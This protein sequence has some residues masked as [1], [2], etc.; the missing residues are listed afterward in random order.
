MGRRRQ[1]FQYLMRLPPAALAQ[2]P[3][4]APPGP[5][6]VAQMVQTLRRHGQR[7]PL[8]AVQTGPAG[9]AGE[10]APCRLVL[11][12]LRLAA[13]QRLGWEQV[14]VV[15]LPQ[16]F[17]PELAAIEAPHTDGADLWRLAE[18]L[19]SLQRRCGWTQAQVGMAIGRSR[20]Y[21][22][23]LLAMLEIRPAARALIAAHP[24]GAG[25]SARHLR[26]IGRTAPARQ[27]RLAQQI[28]TEGLSTKALEQRLRRSPV[29]RPIIKVR[30]LR[31]PGSARGPQT[32]QEWRRYYRKLRTDLHG[33]DTQEAEALRRS[34]AQIAQARR[35]QLVARTEAR[36]QRKHLNRELRRATRQLNR[37]G[38]L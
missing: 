2:P 26:Y 10:P 16:D 19:A 38:A 6:A 32:T 5:D 33:I 7:D 17:A 1:P 29:E 20:D 35:R 14:Q 24:A 11:G 9:D 36:T 23:G 25:L 31:Q 27:A 18:A 37:R 22:A 4:E 3:G 8:L 34:E 21:V 12:W 30:A 15:V 13:V 28:L